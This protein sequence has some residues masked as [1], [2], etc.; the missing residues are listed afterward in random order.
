MKLFQF[1]PSI[2]PDPPPQCSQMSP[3]TLRGF[4]ELLRSRPIQS[5]ISPLSR[6]S[7]VCGNES[8][9]F[10]SVASALS[11]AYFDYLYKQEQGQQEHTPLIPLINIPREDL[12]LRKDIIYMLT[13]QY[14]ISEDLLYF[15]ED[16]V[17]WISTFPKLTIDAILVDH[18]Q[19]VNKSKDL[20]DNVIGIIDHHEDSGMYMDVTPRIIKVTGSCTSLVF[21]YWNGLIGNKLALRDMIKFMYGAVLLDTA[22]FKHKV[23]DSDREA[24]KHYKE[25]DDTVDILSGN[26]IETNRMEQDTFFKTLK[27]AKKD[28]KVLSVRD[29][30]RKDYKQFQF[31]LGSAPTPETSQLTIGIGS[32]VKS[33]KW[34]YK[35]YKGIEQFRS[36]CESF[37]EEFQLDLLII[38]SSF[39]NKESGSFTREMAIVC[40]ATRVDITNALIYGMTPL[41]N[42][43][44]WDKDHQ[45]SQSTTTTA[46]TTQT[47]HWEF[48]QLNVEASRKQVVP[49]IKAVLEQL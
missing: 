2:N 17:H 12:K 41:L 21:N 37:R 6:L 36:Q 11:Y 22:N 31:P 39:N 15:H 49:A 29:I 34:L 46:T 30:I 40:D 45:P 28:I 8:A 25:A 42:L 5:F 43:Q 38:M 13:E 35:E 44:P 16:L 33:L 32:M 1:G 26:H 10:D 27:K 7:V 19:L 14:Q 9:D 23:E 24:L 3:N 48:Q 4:L 47:H 20:I 18:N